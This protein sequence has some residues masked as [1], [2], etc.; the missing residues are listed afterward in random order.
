MI[1]VANA[2]K[3]GV[4]KTTTAVYLAGA[5]AARGWRT[6]LVDGDPQG[7]SSVWAKHAGELPFAVRSLQDKGL[8]DDWECVVIDTPPRDVKAVRE[9]LK[10]ADQVVVP[11]GPSLIEIEELPATVRL[12]QAAQEANPVL[13]AWILLTRVRAGTRSASE[14]REALESMSSRP[15]EAPAGWRPWP[16]TLRTGIPLREAIAGSFGTNP[17][18]GGSSE[19]TRCYEDVLAEV[20]GE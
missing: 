8:G 13:R 18:G 5:S 1:L 3:G 6:V 7:S 9:G 12:I 2:R 19:G 17:F 14:V 16:A 4:G 20:M 11:V 15:A 10:V